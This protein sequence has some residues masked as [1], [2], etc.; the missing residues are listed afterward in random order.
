MRIVKMNKF[1]VLIFLALSVSCA[2]FTMIKPADFSRYEPENDWYRAIASDGVRI[3]GRL[4]EN[5]K[6]G[7]AAMWRTAAEEHLKRKG[8]SVVSRSEITTDAGI[9]ASHAEYRYRYFGREF[10]YTL[11]ILVKGKNIGVV[12]TTGEVKYYEARREAL[13]ASIK[14][15]V[16]K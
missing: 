14:S 9:K 7:S 8:Y 16:F 15:Y 12:E 10:I 13:M 3:K 4:L 6:K 11:T 5:K 1:I 2:G